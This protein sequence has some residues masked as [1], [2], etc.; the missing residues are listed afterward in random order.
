MYGYYIISGAALQDAEEYSVAGCY[1]YT[2]FQEV[3]VW[4][5]EKNILNCQMALEL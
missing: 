4:Q 2:Y 3:S 5:K 1:F